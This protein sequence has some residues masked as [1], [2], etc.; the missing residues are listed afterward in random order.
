MAGDVH[1]VPLS[2]KVDQLTT[3]LSK[4]IIDF[5]LT[6]PFQRSGCVE[7]MLIA[8]TSNALVSIVGRQGKESVCV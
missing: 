5:G 4:K 2:P 3:R 7:T 1:L 6:S 8:T